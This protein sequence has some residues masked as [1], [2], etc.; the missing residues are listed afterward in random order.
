MFAAFWV[1]KRSWKGDEAT[2][3]MVVLIAA[4]V[5][6]AVFAIVGSLLWKKANR[7][8][9]ASRSEPVRFFIQNQL[10]VI[11]AIIAFL[12]LI[13]LIFTNK[14]MGGQQKA[15]AGGI[16]SCGARYRGPREL[17]RSTRRLSSSTPRRP[18]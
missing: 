1:L 11:I 12:P 15:I 16:G 18:P 6:I 9:P 14:N 13:V 5:V 2:V 4:I 7:A 10:G 3:N 8:D 17:P